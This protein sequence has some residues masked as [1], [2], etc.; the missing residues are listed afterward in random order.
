MQAF[1]S[2]FLGSL[3]AEFVLKSTIYRWILNVSAERKRRNYVDIMLGFI[4]HL[5]RI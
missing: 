4:H 1:E 2:H 3:S 5:W